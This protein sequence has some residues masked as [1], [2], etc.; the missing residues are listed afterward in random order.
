MNCTYCKVE[1]P[2]NV[3]FLKD[4]YV[5]PICT[6]KPF[7]N[8][9]PLK[10]ELLQI[11]NNCRQVS[12]IKL[13]YISDLSNNLSKINQYF[14]ES[15]DLNNPWCTI[16]LTFPSGI[17]KLNGGYDGV[18]IDNDINDKDSLI[19]SIDIKDTGYVKFVEPIKQTIIK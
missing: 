14:R 2:E 4:S 5:C 3:R 17:D 13:L 11:Y 16:T 18:Y 19:N 1:A 6:E 15:V 8:Y 9:L 12:G 10:E 7:V